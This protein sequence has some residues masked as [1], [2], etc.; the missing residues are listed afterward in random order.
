MGPINTERARWLAA[1]ILPLEPQI[2]AWLS[3]VTPASLEPDDLI[4]EA[5]AKLVALSSVEHITQPRPYFFQIVRNLI[6]EHVRHAQ[7]VAIEAK[8]ELLSR[9]TVFDDRSPER[10]V[11]GRQELDRL[12]VAIQQLPPGCRRI[13]VMRKLEQLPQKEIAARLGISE[14]TVEKASRAGDSLATDGTDHDE[15]FAGCGDWRT[16]VLGESSWRAVRG[17]AAIG[18]AASQWLGKIDRGLS[19]EE[20][21]ALDEWLAADTRH[22]GALARAQALWIHADRAQVL[23]PL[24]KK[25]GYLPPWGR[26]GLQPR[27]AAAATILLMLSVMSVGW[28]SYSRTHIG[29]STGEIRRIDLADGSS[30]TLDTHSAIAVA[31]SH[32]DRVVRLNA[33]KALFNVAH[34]ANRPFIVEAGSIR[35]RA[36]G[37]VFV[38]QR[39]DQSTVEVTVAR[40][41]V[42]VWRQTSVPEPAVRLV[43]GKRSLATPKEVRMEAPLSATQMAGAVAW[44]EGIIDLDGRTLAEASAEF[45]RYNHRVVVVADPALASQRVIGRF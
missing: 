37:T 19:P 7:V 14:N 8:S 32:N 17:A 10:I 18:T 3:R 15:R 25:L 22:I 45:N 26:L 24:A 4:Q 31:Y 34:D 5:Y 41:T 1:V 39:G 44:Q 20:Q 9:H 13:F 38:V 23:K 33:G 11:S 6:L 27:W 35:V 21:S 30:V 36:V 2:R 12:Y 42:D 43:A 28:H 16:A 29:T 40:G